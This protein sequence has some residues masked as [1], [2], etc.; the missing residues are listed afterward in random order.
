MHRELLVSGRYGFVS[1]TCVQGDAG[2]CLAHDCLRALAMT[3]PY[4]YGTP[5]L[6]RCQLSG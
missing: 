6:L 4:F 1:I 5:H 3:S 2:Q